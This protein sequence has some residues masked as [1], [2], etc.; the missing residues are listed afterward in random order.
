M[1]KNKIITFKVNQD[2]YASIRREA[3]LNKQK[4]SEFIRSRLL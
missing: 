2:D 3:T 4:I 1:K